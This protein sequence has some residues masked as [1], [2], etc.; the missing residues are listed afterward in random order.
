MFS[1]CRAPLLAALALGAAFALP[2]AG[3]A[4]QTR[5]VDLREALTAGA[6]VEVDDVNGSIAVERTSGGDVT[7]HGHASN[8]DSDPGPVVRAIKTG[9]R[10]VICAVFPGDDSDQSGTCSRHG[11]RGPYHHDHLRVDLRVGVPGGAPIVARNVNGSIKATG[12]DAAVDATSVS[13]AIVIATR[14]TANASTVNGSIQAHFSGREDAR[15]NA[16]NGTIDLIVPHD[17]DATFR[18]ETLNGAI[19]AEGIDLSTQ[20]GQFV[21]HTATATLGAGHA[22]ISAHSVN[23]TIHLERR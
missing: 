10:L 16:V 23:G 11:H 9:N 18:A 17:A 22:R 2:A 7:V 21:G 15:F 12:L 5:D 13:G 20:N 19:S 4:Q 6:T 8:G 3:V 14:A 1:T